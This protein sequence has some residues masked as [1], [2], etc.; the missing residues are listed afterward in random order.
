MNNIFLI[1]KPRYASIQK[2]N[3]KTIY[4]P[5]VVEHFEAYFFFA[6]TPHLG[7]TFGSLSE[8]APQKQLP[9]MQLL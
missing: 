1:L 8:Y 7:V 2:K 9:S 3:T 6:S 5:F 4:V